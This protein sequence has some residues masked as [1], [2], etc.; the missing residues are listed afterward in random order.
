MSASE[1]EAK[2]NEIV[3][4]AEGG[5]S[6]T[7]VYL[8]LNPSGIVSAVGVTVTPATASLSD[9]LAATEEAVTPA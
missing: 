9:S 1:P 2:D 8:A 4:A 5:V 7:T 6:R 3:T